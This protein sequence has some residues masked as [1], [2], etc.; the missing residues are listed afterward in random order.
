MGGA[1]QATR[2]TKR[3][4][5]M[6]RQ[7]SSHGF[8]ALVAAGLVLLTAWGNAHALLVASMLG[9]VIGWVFVRGWDGRRATLAALTGAV[10]A[11]VIVAV[12]KHLH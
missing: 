10:V 11:A 3:E 9:L 4:R 5:I 1:K 12:A 2:A 6:Q 8:A 7:M